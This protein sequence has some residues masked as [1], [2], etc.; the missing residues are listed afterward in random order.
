M[1]SDQVASDQS[2]HC[3]VASDQVKSDQS[4]YYPSGKGPI[5]E[6]LKCL[7]TSGYGQSEG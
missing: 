1:A 5:G 7:L 6:W 2:V 4:V 3:K